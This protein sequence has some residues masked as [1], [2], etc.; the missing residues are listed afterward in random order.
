MRHQAQPVAVIFQIRLMARQQCPFRLHRKQTMGLGKRK[1][2][3]DFE[4]QA[5]P[6]PVKMS[7]KFEL[8]RISSICFA[9]NSRRNTFSRTRF[10]GR[11]HENRL[12]ERSV[13]NCCLSGP[14]L[15]PQWRLFRPNNFCRPCLQRRKHTRGPSALVNVQVRLRKCH[16]PNKNGFRKPF[17]QGEELEE[18]CSSL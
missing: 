13:T 10:Q 3:V 17:N 8:R 4:R 9:C 12:Q 5:H 14:A 11:E 16:H 6:V 15:R 1:N 7:F 18:K 2:N